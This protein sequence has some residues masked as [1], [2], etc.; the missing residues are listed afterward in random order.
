MLR[1]ERQVSSQ[2]R[3]EGREEEM[4]RETESQREE[5][6]ETDQQR[7]RGDGETEMG[8]DRE[9]DR[10]GPVSVWAEMACSRLGTRASNA[11]QAHSFLHPLLRVRPLCLAGPKPPPAVFGVWHRQLLLAGSLPV[12]RAAGVHQ[13]FAAR[14]EEICQLW[15]LGRRWHGPGCGTQVGPVGGLGA[16]SYGWLKGST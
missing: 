6:G 16:G 5:I 14:W 7:Q 9:T 11:Q 1:M 2:D 13:A 10:R 15:T 3:D 12:G 8:S 4:E